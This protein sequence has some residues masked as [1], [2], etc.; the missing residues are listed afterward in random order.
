MII[1]NFLFLFVFQSDVKWT[2]NINNQAF[3]F[4]V[5]SMYHNIRL[6][7][8]NLVVSLYWFWSPT[9]AYII[10]IIIIIIIILIIIIIVM[11]TLGALAVFYVMLKNTL[12]CHYW[13]KIQTRRE[14][15]A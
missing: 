12:V 7:V 11:C 8:F 3:K 5:Y 6:V 1:R 9:A 14:H 4:Y 10:I 13:L 15:F 2:S